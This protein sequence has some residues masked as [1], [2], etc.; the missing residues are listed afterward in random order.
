MVTTDTPKIFM[1]FL[2]CG[3]TAS[4]ISFRTCRQKTM[5]IR[6]NPKNNTHSKAFIVVENGCIN[7]DDSVPG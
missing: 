3:Q 5:T 6:A 1:L 2:P 4:T 7:H